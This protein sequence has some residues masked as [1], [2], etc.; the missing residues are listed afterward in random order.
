M[1]PRVGVPGPARRL[2]VGIVPHYVDVNEPILAE[3][4]RRFPSARLVPVSAPP[5]KFLQQLADCDLVL[6]S[7]MHGL[8]AA[9]SLGIPNAWMRLSDRL[10]GGEWKFRDYYSVFGIEPAAL[11]PEQLC[12][13]TEDDL[14]RIAASHPISAE[15]VQTIVE[16]LLAACPFLRLPA[17]HESGDRLGLSKAA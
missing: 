1:P 15:A 17:E 12:R 16:G 14:S 13:L 6:S 4:L 3:L 9:D 11:K 7:A 2:R 8:I 5:R 10:T